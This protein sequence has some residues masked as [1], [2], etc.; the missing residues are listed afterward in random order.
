LKEFDQQFG[1]RPIGQI[2]SATI[3]DLI[4][5]LVE[6]HELGVIDEETACRK[7]NEFI[8]EIVWTRRQSSDD[9]GI[10]GVASSI[11]DS[12]TS[13]LGSLSRIPD[14]YGPLSDLHIQD[15]I[16]Q[17][18]TDQLEC[19]HDSGFSSNVLR[20]N[21]A[22]VS[23][24]AKGLEFLPRRVSRWASE[25]KIYFEILAAKKRQSII[26]SGGIPAEFAQEM[27]DDT[28]FDNVLL[29]DTAAPSQVK[30]LTQLSNF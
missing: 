24:V 1:S 6:Q 2:K 7:N 28:A 26:D 13:S 17:P 16:S 5:F 12:P 27:F 9:T 29:I 3:C 30:S 22:S 19:R 23:S 4:S 15:E 25:T 11:G 18:S 8:S 20:G 21:T 14:I 10:M